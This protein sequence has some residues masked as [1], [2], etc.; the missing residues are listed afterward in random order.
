M[1]LPS[2][3]LVFALTP[4]FLRASF[5]PL[6]ASFIGAGPE[7]AAPAAGAPFGFASLPAAFGAN[8]EPFPPLRPHLPRSGAAASKAW[9][10]A[11]F[12]LFGSLSFG[13]F[14]LRALSV[15]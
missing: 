12:R 10:S 8:F 4:S 5:L 6:A 9:H 1:R 11:K 13:I 15:I 7:G 3:S 2:R 14:A